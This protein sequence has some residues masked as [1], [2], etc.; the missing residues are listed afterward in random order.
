MVKLLLP[1]FWPSA[2]D[3][4]RVSY[5]WG[6]A[7]SPG[8]TIACKWSVPLCTDLAKGWASECGRGM[9]AFPCSQ[10]WGCSSRGRRLAPP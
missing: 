1:V 8:G 5:L 7:A 9:C 2:T 10:G 4:A 6:D 3:R